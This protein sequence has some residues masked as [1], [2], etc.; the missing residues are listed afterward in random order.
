MEM[1]TLRLNLYVL[2]DYYDVSYA[3]LSK[4]SGVI[5][6]PMLVLFVNGDRNLSPD[7]TKKLS[8]YVTSKYG[9]LL[10][11]YSRKRIQEMRKEPR[12]A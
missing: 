12:F 1:N 7:N 4:K 11:D 10:D 9:V 5:S 6:Q 8:D 2:H 3:Q